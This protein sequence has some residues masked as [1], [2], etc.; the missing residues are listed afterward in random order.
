MPYRSPAA[1]R[2]FAPLIIALAVL[3]AAFAAVTWLP[4]RFA[5]DAWRAER[6]ADA[7]DM[8]KR[9]S[10]LRVWPGQYHQVLA[11]A[12]LSQGQRAD[13]APHL[14]SLRK[15]NL[16][17]SI[18]ST[19]EVGERLL[20]RGAYADFLAY[21]DALQESETTPDTVLYRAAAQLATKRIEAAQRTFASVNRAQ[22][23]GGRWTALSNAL[24]QRR[25]GRY[26]FAVDRNGK[27]IAECDLASDDIVA[28]DENFEAFVEE[29]AGTFTLEAAAKKF[30]KSE[31][32]VMTLDADVQRAAIDALKGFRGS[33]VAIDP[34]TNE[35]L[36]IASTAG[37]GKLANLALEKQYEP[38]S[39]MKVVTALD[40]LVTGVAIDPLFPYDCKGVLEIDG[41]HFRDWMEDGHG[42][43]ET[44]DVAMARSCNI[45]FADIG[46]R[47]GL[48]RLRYFN[49]RTG[50]GSHA[51]LGMFSVPLGRATRPVRNNF[52]TALF[53][54]GLEHETVTTLHLAMISTMLANRGVMTTPR[55]Y[56][57]RRSVLGD[58]IDRPRRLQ[59]TRLAQPQHVE[60]I[61]QS[62]RAVVA[63][64]NGTG[65]RAQ[66]E[67]VTLAMKTGTA[68]KEP[69]D[70]VA[71][72]L[73]PV[74]APTIAFA[75]V[76]E[77]A[78]PAEFAAAKIAHDFIAALRK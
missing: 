26:P 59:G 69:Y 1:R 72:G 43:M 62:M 15:G 18:L 61:L 12:H 40:A 64:A 41:R 37:T 48:S 14:E 17:I 47:T 57:A 75:L 73:A 54:I 68:G 49:D 71:I 10:T 51:N 70:A 5:R 58:A 32:V 38:G 28:V 23:D 21:D 45:V 3:V 8:A 44:L 39:V 2:I 74:E 6:T 56:R 22:L 78:G 67:G 34:R 63:D 53:S 27:T 19:A 30:G 60:R 4:L 35:V 55:I 76:A 46:L 16:W 42:K 50:L 9:W 13:A 33:L 66:V 52:E 77:G 36:A 11:A 24:E 25:A 20:K 65:R 7:I 29:G 31:T